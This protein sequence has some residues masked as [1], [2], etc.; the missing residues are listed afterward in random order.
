MCICDALGLN[1]HKATNNPLDAM[2]P[3]KR[4]RVTNGVGSHLKNIENTEQKLINAI[5]DGTSL[6]GI[7]DLLT[8]AEKAE[9]LQHLHKIVFALYRAFSLLISKDLFHSTTVPD[10]QASVVRKWLMERFDQYMEILETNL[11]STEPSISVR[12]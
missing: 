11:D 4:R 7:S 2:Q 1:Y 12:K 10:H 9:D 8:M 6:N 3:A 5:N